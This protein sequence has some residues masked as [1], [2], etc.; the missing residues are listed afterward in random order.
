MKIVFR[1]CDAINSLH[2]STDGNNPRPF[3]LHK[4][5]IIK[6]SA[7]SLKESVKD[8]DHQF[9]LIGDRVSDETWSFLKNLLNPVF[10]FNSKERLGDGGSLLE[11]SKL[12]MTFKDE[13][14]IYFAEDDYLHDPSTFSKKLDSFLKFSDTNLSVPWFVHPTDYPDQ[15]TR[16]LRRCYIFQTD[17]GYW[18]EVAT[19]THTFM[20]HKKHYA[21]FVDFFRECHAEDGNDGKLSTIFGKEALCFSPLPGIATHMHRGT[22]SNY[23]NWEALIRKF[24]SENIDWNKA[25]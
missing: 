14:L 9:Y 5:E 24:A 25:M 20:T 11:C 21:K 8:I 12:A 23:V 10:S 19:T 18:R 2:I 7:T 16:L 13:D 15:Y 1:A 4:K 3:N 6:I 17:F 22:Y